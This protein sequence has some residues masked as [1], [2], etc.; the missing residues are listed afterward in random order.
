VAT[1]VE[2]VTLITGAATGIGAA[3][4]RRLA[5]PGRGLVLTTRS[6]EADLGG[7]AAAARDAGAT[8][9]TTLADLSTPA[10][11]RDLCALAE[12]SF[13]RL[14]AIVANAGYADRT[15]YAELTPEGLDAAHDGMTAAF[16]HLTQAA[17]PLLRTA[18]AGRVVA[19]S[20]FVA[21][22]FRLVG[23]TFP[24][25]AAAKA[26][27]EA[28][29]KALAL[30]LAGDGITVNCVVPGH[31]EKETHG[32]AARAARREMVDG[33]IPMA[34]LGQPDEVAGLIAFLLSPDAG[35]ITG[36]CL[37]IDGGLTL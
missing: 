22:R 28:L 1:E 26:G 7:V 35:Y 20:S 10:A 25:S 15:P 23:E 2:Q 30:E 11:N 27:L 12:A 21:H 18:P 31:I 4:A 6:N 13:G 37:H 5:T 29:A 33:L 24:A 34:R 36:Q 32:E 17:L 9:T 16:L 3:L 8:V 19:L 14:D